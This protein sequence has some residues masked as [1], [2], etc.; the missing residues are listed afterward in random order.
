VETVMKSDNPPTEILLERAVLLG[1]LFQSL[2][3][4]CFS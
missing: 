4:A 1:I 2:R 3:G